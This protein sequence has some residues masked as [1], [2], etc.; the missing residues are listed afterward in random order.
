MPVINK[1]THT[2]LNVELQKRAAN[3]KD[4]FSA[5]IETNYTC[6]TVGN[7]SEL[8]MAIDDFKTILAEIR[9]LK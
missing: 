2:R 4:K 7:F 9:R 1:T 3:L 6:S 5:D 8:R